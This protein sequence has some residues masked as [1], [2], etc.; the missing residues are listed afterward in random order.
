MG[1]MH[2]ER[3]HQGAVA[4]ALPPPPTL[5]R[6]DEDG[7]PARGREDKRRWRRHKGTRAPNTQVGAPALPPPS[8]MQCGLISFLSCRAL[9]ALV[10]CAA[11]EG[12]AC[13]PVW[14]RSRHRTP[15]RGRQAGTPCL[16]G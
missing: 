1:W 3:P 7:H 16:A 5:C 14:V 4:A 12:R 2:A 9:A 15:W 6:R 11:D 13:G 8:A 10:S